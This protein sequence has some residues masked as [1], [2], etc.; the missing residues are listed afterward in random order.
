M[1]KSTVIT[2]HTMVILL[3]IMY[4]I[5][6]T[7]TLDESTPIQPSSCPF[8]MT[9]KVPVTPFNAPCALKCPSP[10]YTDDEWDERLYVVYVCECFSYISFF[11]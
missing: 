6:N 2:N 7:C 3:K 8:P 9:K 5:T 1:T 11:F 10:M 4:I